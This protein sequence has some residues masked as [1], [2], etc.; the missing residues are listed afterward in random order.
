VPSNQPICRSF[1]N[2]LAKLKVDWFSGIEVSSVEMVQTYVAH[3]YGIGVTV[4]VP[5]MKYHP[6]VRALPLTD[7]E[8]VSFGVLWQG[9]RTVLLDSFLKK[10]QEAAARL[11]SSQKEAKK[12]PV[13]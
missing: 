6:Q 7:F 5:Q 13:A 10:L 8:P 12:D 11:A 4:A 2:G 9:K 3:G 1:Q